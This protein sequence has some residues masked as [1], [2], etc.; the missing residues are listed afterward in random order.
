V[1]NDA[2]AMMVES[3]LLG[4]MLELQDDQ[5]RKS[6]SLFGYKGAE[7]KQAPYSPHKEDT[8]RGWTLPELDPGGSQR[9]RSLVPATTPRTSMD[10]TRT[11]R[12]K[13]G[14]L[15]AGGEADAPVM[16]IDKRCLSCSGN[17]STVLAGFKLAC[18]SYAPSPVVY[19]DMPHSRSELIKLRMDLL[20]QAK[21]QL[22]C[23]ID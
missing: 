20:A 23:T 1:R 21:E 5:D 3:E 12:R 18:L 10:P 17:A 9:S 16:T 11:P 2:L 13:A 15:A 8:A 6:I 14:T 22:R 19:R 4:A 7:G